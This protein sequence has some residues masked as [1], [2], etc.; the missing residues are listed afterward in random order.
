[1]NSTVLQEFLV[2]LGFA[3]DQNSLS[4]FVGGIESASMRIAAFGAAMTAVAAVVI[5]SVNDIANENRALGLLA[6]QLGST[7]G[8]VDDF[9]D[10]ADMLGISNETATNSLKTFAGNVSDAAMGIGRA[11]IVFEKLHVAVKDVTGAMR[12]ATE[13]MADLQEKMQGMGRAQQIRIMEKLG[14]DP[15]M[16]AMFNDAFH[17]TKYIADE[18]GKIDVAAGFNLDKAIDESNQFAQSWKHTQ[19]ELNLVKMLFSKM[20]E[21]IAVNMMPKIREGVE[22]F[23]KTV[24]SARHLIMDNAKQIEA[25]LEP[26]IDVILRIGT[27]FV[28]LIGTAFSIIS[29]VLKPVFDM[30]VNVNNATNGWAGYLAAALVAWK[31]FNLGFLLTPLGA[32]IGLSVAVLALIDDFQTWREGGDSLI[33]WGSTF[34]GVIFWVTSAIVGLAASVVAVSAITRTWAIVQ[35]IING[36][37]IAFNAIMYANPIVLA[38]AAIVALIVAG[39]LLVKNWDVV[40]QW[41]SGFFGWFEDKWNKISGIVGKITGGLSKSFGTLGAKFK[42]SIGL[43]VNHT[44]Q[45]VKDKVVPIVQKVKENVAPAIQAVK[46]KVVPVVQAVKEKVVPAI[47]STG[48]FS[49]PLGVGRNSTTTVG[50]AVVNQSTNININGAQ[51]PQAVAQAVAGH[52]VQVNAQVARNMKPAVR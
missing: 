34:G 25:V 48:N 2:K 33:D 6:Q 40:K 43:N 45:A 10:T 51:N 21:A 28:K 41:F 13:V 17:D 26:I 39:V 15:A 19:V 5:K 32:I 18:L 1:M 11:K 29:A 37:M 47:Q 52:Q 27:A 44:V 3:V 23:G 38:I 30:M 22:A 31:L 12:P 24:E 20:Y 36:V 14:L 49:T 50:G 9:I 8:A 16:L 35:G 42:D 46:E 7:T 4:G